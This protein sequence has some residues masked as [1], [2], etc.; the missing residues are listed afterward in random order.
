MAKVWVA[1]RDCEEGRLPPV[2]LACGEPAR[3]CVE[4]DLTRSG[5]C[6]RGS[7]TGWRLGSARSCLASGKGRFAC[8]RAPITAITFGTDAG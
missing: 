6:D 3:E 4:Q 7:A 5:I 1:R 8:R 2:C